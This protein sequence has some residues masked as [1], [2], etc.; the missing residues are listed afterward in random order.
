[1]A[2]DAEVECYKRPCCSV[3]EV[4][5]QGESGSLGYQPD[6]YPDSGTGEGNIVS[7]IEWKRVGIVRSC[8]GWCLW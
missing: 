3:D 4:R 8:S 5:E 1:M 6:A 2:H 7:H